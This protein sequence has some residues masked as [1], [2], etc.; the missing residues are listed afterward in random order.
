MPK[1]SPEPPQIIVKEFTLEEIDLGIEKLH[2]RIEDAQKLNAQKV[3]YNDAEV[4]N[5]ENRIRETVREV[6][7]PNSPEFRDHEHRRIW[8]GGYNM[9]DTYDVRQAKFAAG[10]PQTIKRLKGLVAWLEE[11]RHDLVLSPVAKRIATFEDLNIHSRIAGVSHDLYSD[12]HYGS[13]VFDASKALINYVKERSGCYKLDGA[14]LMRKVFSRKNPILAFN[15]LKD[16]SD[17]DEQEGMM[18]LYEGAVLAIRN[19]RG[20]TFVDD[21]PERALQYIGL[22]SMLANRLE[23]TNCVKQKQG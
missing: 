6:F 5:T 14:P 8:H 2:R 20:H 9:F 1:K 12:D 17:L 7:G 13:A 15:T 11:K 16:Q 21:S 10:I 19:P 4:A 3:S 18:H 23:E 22:L